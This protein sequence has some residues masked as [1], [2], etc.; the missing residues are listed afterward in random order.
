MLHVWGVSFVDVRY[1]V[2]V[3]VHVHDRR[4]LCVYGDLRSN[5]AQHPNKPAITKQSLR[6]TGH[7]DFFRLAEKN[8]AR[9]RRPHILHSKTVYYTLIS[10][11]NIHSNVKELCSLIAPS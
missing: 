9:S 8:M 1:T 7:D 4:E 5:C 10:S 2:H 3:H 11:R 6:K